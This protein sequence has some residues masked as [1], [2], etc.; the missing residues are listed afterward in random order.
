MS[1]CTTS[2]LHEADDG[3]QSL[4][5]GSSSGELPPKSTSA[6][7]LLLDLRFDVDM[8]LPRPA[9]WFGIPW[10]GI[11]TDRLEALVVRR[12]VDNG[13]FATS[14][15]RELSSRFSSA[16]ILILGGVGILVLL[17]SFAIG[18][19]EHLL[20]D[21][22]G[23]CFALGC[24]SCGCSLSEQSSAKACNETFDGPRERELSL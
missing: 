24:S 11:A 2:N 18:I 17:S 3:G 13:V 9:I 15:G 7:S 22:G 1:G 23:A 10:L 20:F 6:D 8:D 14:A 4:E 5:V 16:R 21:L 19:G 12:L